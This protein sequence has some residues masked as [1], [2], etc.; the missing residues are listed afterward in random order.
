MSDIRHLLAAG[1]LLGALSM[2]SGAA[3]AAQG[4]D[5]CTG[6][7]DSLPATITTQGT[8][9]LRKD[10]STGI[11]SGNA[12]TIAT[13]NVTLD[14]NDFKVGGLVAGD[15]SK[16]RGI[17]AAQRQNA[18]IRNCTIRGFDFGVYVDSGD[19]HLVEDNLIDNSLSLGIYFYRV[20]PSGGSVIRRNRI[21]D[22]GGSPDRSNTYGISATNALVE[23][24]LVA[25]VFAATANPTPTGISVSRSMVRGNV[26][27]GMVAVASGLTTGIKGSDSVMERNI[28][29]SSGNLYPSIGITGSV[30][31]DN[32]GI[33]LQ[34]HFDCW[35]NLNNRD[36]T[37][38]P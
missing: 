26:V 15:G 37:G 24:N 3:E 27:T 38:S 20:G 31:R 25:G 32:T 33:K 13:N 21:V 2:A 28:V 1:M 4:Y 16:A 9:C 17:F 18:T 14:C 10:L 6:F 7:I 8:W 5:N 19:G 36:D 22:T 35:A 34:T 29:R 11:T 30:C 12:I 23:D